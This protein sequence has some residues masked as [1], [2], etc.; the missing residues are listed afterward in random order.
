MFALIQEIGPG[1]YFSAAVLGIVEDLSA[2]GSWK[3][4]PLYKLF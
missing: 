1:W 4:K 2:F 3:V